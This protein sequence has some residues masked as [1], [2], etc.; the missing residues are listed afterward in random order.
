MEEKEELKLKASIVA[1]NIA[2]MASYMEEH[3]KVLDHKGLMYLL[4]KILALHGIEYK[5]DKHKGN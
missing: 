2:R 5:D 4:I 1:G 3:N